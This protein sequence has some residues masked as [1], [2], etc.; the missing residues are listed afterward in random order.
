MIIQT[1]EH[2]V[3]FNELPKFCEFLHME[4]KNKFFHTFQ[5]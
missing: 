4:K 1:Q 5:N 2:I 3:Y